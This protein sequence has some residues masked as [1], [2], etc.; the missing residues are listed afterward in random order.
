MSFK[1][2]LALDLGISS[3]GWAVTKY[4]DDTNQAVIDDFG[5]RLFEVPEKSDDHT[6]KALIRRSARSARRLKRRRVTR[7]KELKRLFENIGLLSV[8]EINNFYNP[9]ISKMHS[10]VFLNQ[11]QTKYFNPYEYRAKGLTNQLTPIELAVSILHICAH[12]GYENLFNPETGG[13]DAQISLD[14]EIDLNDP[15][16]AY[17]NSIILGKKILG[18]DP[19]NNTIAKTVAEVAIDPTILETKMVGT[20]NMINIRN[21]NK[22]EK[23]AQNQKFRFLFPRNALRIE[24]EKILTEQQKYYS[25]LTDDVIANIR[26]VVFRQRDFEDGYGPLR[27]KNNRSD[28]MNNLKQRIET[29]LAQS[30]GEKTPGSKMLV[31]QLQAYKLF[32]PFTELVGKCTFY[33]DEKRFIKSSIVF[34]IYQLAVEISKFSNLIASQ[35]QRKEFQTKV[36]I[37]SLF[38]TEFLKNTKTR[39]KKMVESYGVDTTTTKNVKIFENVKDKP[40]EYIAIIKSV[41][42]DKFEKMKALGV[43]NFDILSF[44]KQNIFDDDGLGKILNENITPRRRIS[45]IESWAKDNDI[46]INEES[47]KAIS[48][49]AAKITTTS[50]LSKKAMLEVVEHFMNGEVAGVYQDKMKQIA[51]EKMVDKLQNQS[52]LAPI[53][54]PDIVRNPVVFRAL[55][56]SRKVLKAL[57]KRYDKFDRINIETTRELGK[58][59]DERNKLTSKMKKNENHNLELENE[60]KKVG[61]SV[62][63]TN[64][65]KIKLWVSQNKKCPYSLR[66]IPIEK[67]ASEELQIDHIIPYSIYPNDSFDNKVLVY[68][69]E[70]QEKG[71]MEAY[72]YIATSKKDV[73]SSYQKNITNLLS[74]N[75]ISQTK[76][77]L[78]TISKFGEE[79]NREFISRNLN[80]TSYITRYIRNWLKVNIEAKFGKDSGITIQ[81]IKGTIT[82]RFR[83][84]WL[85]NS[86]WGLDQKVRE[87]TPWHHAIDAIVLSQ[88]KNEGS[89]AFAE[90][91]ILIGNINNSKEEDKVKQARIDEVLAKWSDASNYIW[92]HHVKNAEQKL[93]EIVK[94]KWTRN[95]Y[96][97]VKNLEDVVV[98]RMPIELEVVEEK[99]VHTITDTDEKGNKINKEMTL[100]NRVPKFARVIFPEEYMDKLKN[101]N[102]DF[103]RHYPCISYKENNKIKGDFRDSKNVVKKS[104]AFDANNKFN[105]EKYML[106]V[107]GNI[108]ETTKYY[109][110]KVKIVDNKL[111]A[112]WIKLIDVMKNKDLLKCEDGE[113]VIKK[114]TIV[115]YIDKNSGEKVYKHFQSK[116]NGQICA[117]LIATVYEWDYKKSKLIFNEQNSYDSIGN[118]KDKLEVHKITILGYLR[119]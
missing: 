71:N 47:L 37:N 16:K 43:E 99:R 50:Q 96:P 38:D 101:V 81:A 46:A 63:A 103:N 39:I 111:Q 10:T 80:D 14:K 1:K 95:I 41:A 40:L 85:R 36:I 4:D 91:S 28:A 3:C 86:G 69:N 83:R 77:D 67:L 48:T 51:N 42:A 116:K 114:G 108:W 107:H 32:K 106:D 27:F 2:I 12:R 117:N 21:N 30:N 33:P 110:V 57:F 56:E 94:N 87:I 70:N 6:S 53:T 13:D 104:T 34:S 49:V 54:D 97:L 98:Q 20:N 112:T 88:F 45:A 93:L 73:L 79:E 15:K 25:Q 11:D 26:T 78:L 119:F 65:L 7:L 64:R 109:G 61:I 115:S 75:L 102:G 89:I 118:W 17:D 90:D 68:A 44:I 19:I 84:N 8:S 76:F 59:S 29:M 92:K 62:N 74:K 9:E 82:S 35:E 105:D 55:N 60:L 66:E 58:S 24:L 18:Y 22:S 113:F 52:F 5:V 23:K 72:R 31:K 100:K